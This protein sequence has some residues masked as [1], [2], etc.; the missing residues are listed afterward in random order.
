MTRSRTAGPG[1]L[2]A[3]LPFLARPSANQSVGWLEPPGADDTGAI[4]ERFGATQLPWQKKASL[5]VVAEPGRLRALAG[6]RQRASGT[7]W[8]VDLLHAPEVAAAGDA[9]D[10]LAG[11]AASMGARRAFLRLAV[12]SPV[13]EAARTGGFMPYAE[14]HLM[15]CEASRPASGEASALRVAAAADQHGLFRLYNRAV[16]QNVR[17]AEAV[18]LEEWAA[19][20]QP[21]GAHSTAQF[22][23][24]AD[25]EVT[26][27]VR[28][29]QRGRAT[30]F[31]VLVDPGSHGAV[32]GVVSA[33]CALLRSGGPLR[34]FVPD[35]LETVSLELE[36]RGFERCA[37]FV[38]L[39]RQLAQPIAELAPARVAEEAAWIT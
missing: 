28:T 37:D 22:V 12:D 4:L 25:G 34:T 39:G 33:A 31:D 32:V 2:A 17:A 11:N 27:W 24:E 35:Y 36:G 13:L 1:D 7:A 26:A 23:A 10:R 3:I 6:G 21:L 5:A 20:Q 19:T 9:L 18:T 16:P 14:E 30:T 15:L 38:L 8:E 29:A